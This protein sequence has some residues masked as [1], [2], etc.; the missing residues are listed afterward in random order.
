MHKRSIGREWPGKLRDYYKSLAT[1]E[2]RPLNS[3]L[4]APWRAKEIHAI[5]TDFRAAFGACRFSDFAFR[6][7]DMCPQAIG[8]AVASLM[9]AVLKHH[10]DLFT[11][12]DCRG[13]GYPD[14]KLVNLSSEREYPFEIKATSK[15]QA[16]NSRVVLTSASTK[17]RELF[18]PPVRHLIATVHYLRTPRTIRLES[19]RLNF[20]GPQS[21]VNVR[22]EVA[23]TSRLLRQ[24]GR[25]VWI[26]GESP[27]SAGGSEE[28]CH[29][30]PKV[31]GTC[32][33][34]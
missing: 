27:P 7:G 21:L 30:A 2:G 13:P 14:F 18:V 4:V 3:P 6:V 33:A 10:L 17:L 19:L 20:L 28:A 16:T 5:T 22:F 8:N 15:R 32:H 29:M 26:T 9:A 11:I 24:D 12:D 34:P 1:L 25:S 31:G 23:V